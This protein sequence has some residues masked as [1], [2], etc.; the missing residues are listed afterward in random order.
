[1]VGLKFV[2][3]CLKG[4][5]CIVHSGYYKPIRP[6]QEYSPEGVRGKVGDGFVEID[7]FEQPGATVEQQN[8]EFNIHFTT[9]GFYR[10][11][12]GFDPSVD[13]HVY[14]LEWNEGELIWYIDGKKSKNL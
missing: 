9:D 7:I 6:K 2:V 1:M 12:M 13:F 5:D 10:C 14:A 11:P 4:Q 3:G 8:N